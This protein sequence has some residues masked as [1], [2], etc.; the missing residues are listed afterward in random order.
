M[1]D[2]FRCNAA[3]R[4]HKYLATAVQGGQ[5]GEQIKTVWART[6]NLE[7]ADAI[8]IFRFLSHL[9][10]LT[11]EVELRIKN[12]DDVNSD[13]MLRYL[14]SVREGLSCT[15]LELPWGHCRQNL[16]DKALVDLEYCADAIT[17]SY[18]ENPLE[19]SELKTIKDDIDGLFEDL[20]TS[21]LDRDL[22]LLLL[23]LT[24]ELRRAVAEYEIRGAS[25]LR[26]A[27][28]RSVGELILRWKTLE[29]EKDSSE[30]QKLISIL[31]TIDVVLM[32]VL[33]YRPLIESATPFLLTVLGC[34]PT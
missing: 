33:Q 23:D 17:R 27:L 19:E 1:E 12:I 15:N 34:P 10:D 21:T 6:F 20:K 3:G 30:M 5:S 18:I 14:D 31:K 32:K 11:D 8:P 7:Q 29:K 13:L 9:M 26:R 28:A 16:T 24:E 22:R 25:G 4:L 2:S